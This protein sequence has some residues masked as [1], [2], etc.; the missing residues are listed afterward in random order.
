MRL[1][2]ESA[3]VRGRDVGSFVAEAARVIERD[4]QVPAGYWTGWGGQFEQL[5]SAAKRLQ[6]VVPVEL[7]MV[8]G[9]L[10]MMFNNMKDVLLVFTGIPFALDWRCHG[11]VA[12]RYPTINLGGRGVHCVV[13]SRGAQWPGNDRVHPQPGE[14]GRSLSDAISEGGLTRLRPVQMTALVA[15]LGWP[16][17]HYRSGGTAAACECGD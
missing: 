9:L 13:G 6:I 17:N 12:S 14:E 11:A 8:F 1:V 2:I 16:G 10:F 3:N 15:S 7:L 5:Q 4:V